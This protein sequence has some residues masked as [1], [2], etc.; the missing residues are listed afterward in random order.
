MASDHRR[1]HLPLH[2]C[3][4]RRDN[5]RRNA[6]PHRPSSSTASKHDTCSDHVAILGS[7]HPSRARHAAWSWG[8]L[9]SKPYGKRC[10]LPSA[11]A[12]VRHASLDDKDQEFPARAR[13]NSIVPSKLGR[14]SQD[15]SSYDARAVA[16]RL[17]LV[18]AANVTQ[19]ST[20]HDHIGTC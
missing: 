16:N 8:D 1:L 18:R 10:Q 19:E 15:R 6:H 20:G 12:S 14:A 17:Q 13:I 2:T 11:A 3:A 7:T 9:D 4:N 5:A